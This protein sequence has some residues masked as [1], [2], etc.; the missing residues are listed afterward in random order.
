VNRWKIPQAL[1]AE[2]RTRDQ[3]CIYCGGIFAAASK[4]GERMSWEHII[5]DADLVI[6]ENIA[7]CCISCNASKGTKELS[8]WLETMYC[9]NRGI[10]S[11]TIA[12]IAQAAYRAAMRSKHSAA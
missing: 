5:N 11:G 3:A 7:L 8:A 9:R 4:R 2:V 12:P 6:R 1:E 10:H